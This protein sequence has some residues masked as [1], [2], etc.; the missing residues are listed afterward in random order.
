MISI[1]LPGLL[2]SLGAGPPSSAG[3]VAVPNVVTVAD[4]NVEE[5]LKEYKEVTEAWLAEI[6]AASDADK[7]RI[8]DRKPAKD[9][10]GR[11]AALADQGDP[12]ACVWVIENASDAGLLRETRNTRV[13]DAYRLL[14]FDYPDEADL[15]GEAGD[16][17][18]QHVYNVP[19]EELISILKESFEISEQA[20][21]KA[22]KAY[23]IGELMVRAEGDKQRMAEGRKW[24]DRVQADFPDSAY[25]ARAGD[26][27]FELENLVLGAIAP[28]FG[29][30][31][32]DD[33][34]IKLSDY[35]GKIVVIDF[36]GFW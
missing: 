6:Q 12:Q 25:A 10:W 2:L 14:F 7:R 24:L 26:I 30:K 8:F 4:E 34:E 16:M 28:D 13:L 23:H 32:I 31:S 18:R 35:R 17:L 29:G 21:C 9:F 3:S 33:T 11:F 15:L 19:K 20:E 1:I 5:L 27:I 36:F 22:L